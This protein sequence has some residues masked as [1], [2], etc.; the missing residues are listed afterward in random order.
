MIKINTFSRTLSFGLY[1]ICSLI[2]ALFISWVILASANFAYP[3]LHDVM[4]I[5]QHTAKYG[6]QNRYRHQFENTDRDERIRLF[7]AINES[8]H[9]QG[10][11]LESIDYFDKSTKTKINSLLHTDEVLHLQDVAKLIDIFRYT[12]L[13]A[14]F[15]WLA[16]IFKF[17]KQKQSTP[18]IKQQSLS[19]LVIIG[20]CTITVLLI[21]PVTVF[22]AFHE[23]FF[24]ANHKWF[25]YYQESLMTILMKAP[26]LFGYIA[27]L[28]LVLAIPIFITMNLMGHKLLNA[29]IYYTRK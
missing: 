17:Y 26:F 7:A 23:W 2:C 27:V 8:I 13:A 29:L 3:V 14:L 9:Q 5:G 12:S 11:G 18:N 10:N 15:I 25:F 1:T 4:D 28:I 22:Y 6:P 19:T 16:L 21:G 24:P 20:V